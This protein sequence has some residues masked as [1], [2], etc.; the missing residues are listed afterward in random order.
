VL[1]RALASLL[2]LLGAAAVGLGIASA[3]V[4]R[5][6]DT[7][8]ATAHGG[9]G[10]TLMMTD[11][12]VLEM[13]ADEVSI[14]ASAASGE[15][16]VVALGRTEDVEAWI[17]ADPYTRVTGLTDRSTLRTEQDAAGAPDEATPSPSGSA[18]EGPTPSAPE[19]AAPAEGEAAVTDPAADPAAEPVAVAA[20]DP[21][22][23]D[24]WVEEKTGERAVSFRYD[25]QPGRWSILVAST[26]AGAGPVDLTLTWP[27]VVTTPWL[28]PLVA[29]GA[30]LLL[31]GL[32]WWALLLVRHRRRLRGVV[33]E[34]PVEGVVP[35]PAE[36]VPAPGPVPVGATASAVADASATDVGTPLAPAPVGQP[37][38]SPSAAPAAEE[39]SFARDAPAVV[40]PAVAGSPAGAPAAPLTRR[41]IRERDQQEARAALEEQERA[42][43]GGRPAPTSAAAERPSTPTERPGPPAEAPRAPQPRPGGVPQT[44]GAGSPSVA[45]H[46]AAPA[47]APPPS[48]ASRMS[49]PSAGPL[50]QRAPGSTILPPPAG[51]PAPSLAAPGKAAPDAEPA[52]RWGRLAS[53]FQRRKVVVPDDGPPTPDAPA[54][55]PT[56]EPSPRPTLPPA[57]PAQSADAWRRAWGFPQTGATDDD[58]D[59]RDGGDR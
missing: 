17:G 2:C 15:Q 56:P 41:Q 34:T 30:V 12:G 59:Q 19:S 9:D 40:V 55:A 35:A 4:W 51:L 44:G 14:R 18:A 48:A 27:Q 54:D 16:V 21:A 24:L 50:P 7:L 29:A 42:R 53:Q 8:V 11:P 3:T 1:Q 25:A 43:R 13:A 6:S 20:P 45:R 28:V 49:G 37:E 32:L 57:N 31:A 10:T 52:A 39:P 26:G 38:R 23:S 47:S 36:P 58:T 22:G 33:V 5:A 46:S